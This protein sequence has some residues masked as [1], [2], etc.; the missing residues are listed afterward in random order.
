[1]GQGSVNSGAFSD[2]TGL[3]SDPFFIFNTTPPDGTDTAKF[4]GTA[5]PDPVNAGRYT[6]KLDVTLTADPDFNVVIYQASGGQLFWLDE[7]ENDDSVFLGSLQQQG[8][9][10]GLPAAQGAPAKTK[11]KQKQ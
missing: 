4:S 2:A 10:I 3:V 9:L 5:S 11:S 1:V 8:S 6:I 7:E